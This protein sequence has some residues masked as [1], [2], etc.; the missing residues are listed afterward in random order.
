MTGS[1]PLGPSVDFLQLPLGAIA[2]AAHCAIVLVDAAY[3]IVAT[4]EAAARVFDCT[5]TALLGQPLS[6]FVPESRR[7][8]DEAKVQAFEFAGL[9]DRRML[10]QEAIR[11]RRAN[12]G[13]FPAEISISRVELLIEGRQRA[14][15]V[16]ILRDLS[17]ERDLRVEVAKLNARMR[18]VLDLMPV[19]I[20][21]I[22]AHRIVYANRT[23]AGLFGLSDPQQLIGRSIH[24]LLATSGPIT[25]QSHLDT[26]NQGD[27]SQPALIAGTL[28][29]TDGQTRHVEIATSALPD[30]GRTVLQMVIIDVTENRNQIEEQAQHRQELRRLAASVV[31]AREE[32]RR[33]IARELHDELGQR[34]T[35]LKMEISSLRS[36]GPGG[37]ERE[38]ITGMLEMV[39]SSVAALRRISADLRPLIL[40][41]LGL[42]AAIE[43]LARDAARRLG[44]EVTV[45]LGAEDP[46]L[47]QGAD[48]ALYRMVQEALTNVGRHASAT[49]VHIEL[50]QSDSELALT[51][52]DNGSGF[53]DRSLRQEGRYGLLGMRERALAL[54]GRLDID[55]PPG[56][57]GRITVHLPLALGQG[58]PGDR[59]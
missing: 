25:L 44:I 54:G 56:G 49:E 9:S 27:A 18:A 55:T 38:R 42:N 23:A 45:H 19:P 17:D 29:R 40:D 7:A 26:A 20:W 35:A 32:E 39:D 53:P 31:E 24:E 11:A 21:I 51:V 1:G 58:R 37:I 8:A 33:R 57:G 5:Q 30:H 16:A 43:W 22:D 52:R 50:V 2:E 4:N 59:P 15:F 10:S 6:R 46:P 34:L 14:Y 47:A 41:D 28:M 36:P 3:S 13:E 12:G 48:I